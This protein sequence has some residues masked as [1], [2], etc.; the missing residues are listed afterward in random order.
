MDAEAKGA[1][2]L[3][4]EDYRRSPVCV[5]RLYDA[6]DKH[7]VDLLSLHFSLK[8]ASSIR[9][10]MDGLCVRLQVYTVFSSLQCAEFAIPHG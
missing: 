5:R 9:W 1:V 8:R 2:W 10:L 6:L 7:I 3:W 4:V